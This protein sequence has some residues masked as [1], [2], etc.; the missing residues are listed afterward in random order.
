MDKITV[1]H[2]SSLCESPAFILVDDYRKEM[3]EK[4]FDQGGDVPVNG[5]S[6]AVVAMDGDRCVGFMA[7]A[8]Y[9]PVKAIW[10]ESAYVHPEYRRRGIHGMMFD[11][12]VDQAK[13][14]GLTSV[15]G[16]TD[17]RNVAS[18]S[19]MEKQGRE[20][21]GLMYRYNIKKESPVV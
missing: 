19:S 10:I 13:I 11:R 18:I 6:W 7:H 17:V 15:Q 20:V 8:P 3:K 21:F 9:L 1:T 5:H 2:H 16:A 12:V 14:E 4:G